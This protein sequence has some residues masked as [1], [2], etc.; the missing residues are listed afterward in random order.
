MAK[1]LLGVTMSLDGF[2]AGPNDEV[3]L[4]HDWLFG[5]EHVFYRGGSS[6]RLDAGDVEIL[7]EAF[8]MTGAGVIGRR[9]Y[10]LAE[11]PWGDDPPFHV[12][13]FVVTH[14]ANE[15]V[16]KGETSFSF[17]TDGVES[18][19]EEAKAAAGDK[20][21]GI[22]GASITQQCINAGLLDELQIHIAPIILGKGIRLFENMDTDLIK[23]EKTKVIDSPRVT[24]IRYQVIR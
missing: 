1:V 20:H 24:H 23:L 5:G 8:W 11:E 15:K 13:C 21:V 19:I 10:D 2:I 14:R 4:L 12:P 16:V 9:T 22:M 18:A 7:E 3:E 17:V 6:F